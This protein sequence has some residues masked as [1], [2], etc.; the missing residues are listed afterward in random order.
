M[1]LM[2]RVVTASF[3][4][5]HTLLNNVSPFTGRAQ[6]AALADWRYEAQFRYAP[7]DAGGRAQVLPELYAARFGETPVSL[8]DPDHKQRF[9]LGSAGTPVVNGAGQSGTT[10]SVRGFPAGALVLNALDYLTVAYPALGANAR[11]L[12]QT[13]APVTANGSGVASIP[14]LQPLRGS[15]ADGATVTA[16]NPSGLFSITSYEM[17]TDVNG[18]TALSITAREYFA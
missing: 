4:P 15:P 12:H 9:G 16:T 5:R 2:D 18:Y 10:L 11:V 3:V 7:L 8:H 14:L 13:T 6:I 17:E 1:S